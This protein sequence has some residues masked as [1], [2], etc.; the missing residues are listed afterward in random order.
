MVEGAASEQGAARRQRGSIRI[1]RGEPEMSGSP[2]L[3]LKL[4]RFFKNLSPLSAACCV[5]LAN[6]PQDPRTSDSRCRVRNLP[7][8]SGILAVWGDLGVSAN[9]SLLGH[10]WGAK[11]EIEHPNSVIPPNHAK[12]SLKNHAFE[13]AS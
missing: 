7:N 10:P 8:Q 6:F 12:T 13:K 11:P 1:L 4:G 5:E 2:S 3:R 9:R